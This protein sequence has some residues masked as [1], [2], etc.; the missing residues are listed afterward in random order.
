MKEMVEHPDHYQ[1]DGGME[2]I[3][4]MVGLFGKERVADWCHITAFKYLARLGKK[5]NNIQE[6]NKAIWYLQKYKELKQ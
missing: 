4:A 1:G 6:C 2:T 5:D 3:D